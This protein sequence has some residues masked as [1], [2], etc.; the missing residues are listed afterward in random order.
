[1]AAYEMELISG[2]MNELTV[3]V[4]ARLA[5][6]AERVVSVAWQPGLKNAPAGYTVV[7]ESEDA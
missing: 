1:M 4:T 2:D 5:E 7:F 3:A 6:H